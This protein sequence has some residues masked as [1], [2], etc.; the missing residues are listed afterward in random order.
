MISFFTCK[1]SSALSEASGFNKEDKRNPPLVKKA[2]E[3]EQV[4]AN[5]ATCGAFNSKN[6][7]R[8]VSLRITPAAVSCFTRKW[9]T[10]VF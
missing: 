7:A 9:K 5:D 6:Q 3:Q 2:V 1:V 8:R 10:I 4:T